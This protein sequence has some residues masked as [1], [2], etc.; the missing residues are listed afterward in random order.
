MKK[1]LKINAVKKLFGANRWVYQTLGKTEFK[2]DLPE[3]SYPV[4]ITLMKALLK[5]VRDQKTI[6]ECLYLKVVPIDGIPYKFDKTGT[7]AMGM[8]RGF[9]VKLD[10]VKPDWRKDAKSLIETWVLRERREA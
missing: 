4:K 2:I 7:R 8:L 5:R 9:S 6:E 10:G 3:K 1:N